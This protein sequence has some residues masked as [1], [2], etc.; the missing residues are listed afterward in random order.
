MY[1]I[2]HFYYFSSLMLVRVYKKGCLFINTSGAAVVYWAITAALLYVNCVHVWVFL[3][4][5]Y[6]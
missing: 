6:F 2:F 1:H 4:P 3:H 5:V